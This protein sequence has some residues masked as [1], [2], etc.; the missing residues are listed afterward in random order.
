M[1]Q[2]ITSP[3]GPEMERLCREL[4]GLCAEADQTGRWPEDA[5][6]FLAESGAIEWYVPRAYGGQEWDETSLSKA[7]LALSEAFLS[8]TF[9]LTQWAGAC[10]RIAGCENESL[11]ERLLPGLLTGETFATVGISHLTTSRRHLARP[12]LTAEKVE[13][14]YLLNGYAPWV[15]GAEKADRVVTGAVLL[16]NDEPTPLQMLVAAPTDNTA[17]KTPEPFSMVALTS[18]RTGPV[19]FDGLMIGEE[20][21]VAGP[22]EEVMKSGVGAKPGG[23]QTSALALGSAR[24][25]IRILEREALRR[26]ELEEVAQAM[27]AE[28][29]E[30][31][32]HLEASCTQEPTCSTEALRQKANS[33]VL[34]ASQAALTATKGAGYLGDAP[35]GRLCRE[36]LFFLVWSCPAP[37]QNANLCELA[38]LAD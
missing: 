24:A 35:A 33:L 22:V 28:H 15:T 17:V 3:E 13:G 18:S 38:G 36:A 34:R 30:A 20:D 16:E 6:R 11:K 1:S 21:V 37:V 14:G 19:E 9:I 10:R 12:A 27:L 8:A 26:P 7:Y 5:I 2:R 4:Q 23:T 29:K 32:S 25:S 31:I